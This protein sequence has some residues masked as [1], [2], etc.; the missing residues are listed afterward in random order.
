MTSTAQP[1]PDGQLRERAAIPR[2]RFVT[3]VVA[4]VVA[5]SAVS[6]GLLISSTHQA[7]A[8]KPA[9]LAGVHGTELILIVLAGA[10]TI[11]AMLAFFP[12]LA[13]R[14]ATVLWR[15]T[16]TMLTG[17]LVTG[18]VVAWLASMVVVGVP[19]VWEL[20]DLSSRR[21]RDWA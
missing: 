2:S 19:L 17:A 4:A 20:D 13:R 16:A 11:T 9:S 18:T 8:G 15:R 7:S 10:G 3:G 21:P 14:P 1:P 12:P 5:V 6:L